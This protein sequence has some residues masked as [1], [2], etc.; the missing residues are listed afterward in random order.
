MLESR[1]H[2]RV[3]WPLSEMCRLL[4]CHNTWRDVILNTNEYQKMYEVGVPHCKPCDVGRDTWQQ[5]HDH[6]IFYVLIMEWCTSPHV[7]NQR[8]AILENANHEPPSGRP[9]RPYLPTSCFTIQYTDK[10]YTPETAMNITR[11]IRE[12]DPTRLSDAGQWWGREQCPQLNTF[13]RY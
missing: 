4:G 6:S 13:S 2:W 9:D 12:E 7:A 3:I 10:C 5:G 8:T 1:E 11:T